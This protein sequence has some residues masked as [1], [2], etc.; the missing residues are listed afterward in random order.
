VCV[1]FLVQEKKS[2]LL[3]VCVRV[4]APIQRFLFC[5]FR[6]FARVSQSVASKENFHTPAQYVKHRRKQ[7]KARKINWWRAFD[8]PRVTSGTLL[9]L[10]HVL[11][12]EED[13]AAITA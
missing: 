6:I 2:S 3:F 13:G 11:S 4:C 1:L 8:E 10:L 5:F 12:G 7:Q 9:F